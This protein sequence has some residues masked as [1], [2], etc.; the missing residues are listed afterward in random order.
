MLSAFQNTRER[1]E[2][3]WR[4][5]TEEGDRYSMLEVGEAGWQDSIKWIEGGWKEIGR[6][7]KVGEKKGS[8][9][10]LGC[11]N[12]RGWGIGKFSDL[13]QELNE[14]NIDVVGIT[15]T[16]LRDAVQLEGSE[17]VIVSKGRR[18]QDTLGGGVALL[19]RK[20]RNLRVEELDV[21]ESLESEDVLATRVEYVN[22][23]GRPDKLVVVVVYMTVEGERAIR[24]NSRKYGLL[25]KIVREHARERVIVMGDMNAHTGVL[26]EQVNRNGEMLGEFVNE[27]GLENLNETLAEGRVTWSARNQESA[28]DYM[29]VNERMREIVDR[30][31]IDEDGMIDIVSDHNMLVLECKL[32]G[33]E[34]RHAKVKRRKGR[35]RDVG[36]ENF[37]VDFRLDV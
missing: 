35:L 10:K 33:R 5:P 19:H 15:E 28:I 3:R 9:M 17:Y 26:G 24:E 21:G 1:S 34:G 18:M 12:V 30:M 23:Y 13:C 22:E 37:Q 8:C 20:V 4:S 2:G 32:Y 31:W 11:V 7:R 25:K 16:H 14:W 6:S 27:M 29:L 36:W